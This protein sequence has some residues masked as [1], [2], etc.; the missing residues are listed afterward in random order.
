MSWMNQREYPKISIVTPNY[1]KA[2]YLERTILSVLSQNYPNLEYII[3]DGGSTD[4]SVDIIK[5]YADKLTY[6]V[7]E[8]DNGMYYAIKKGFEY[9][10]GEIMAW[11][12]SDDMYHPGA[13]SIVADI[14]ME[15]D[16]V[17]WLTGMNTH[18]DE[19]G[20]TVRVWSATYFSH[21]SFLM[22]NYKYVQQ[23][24]T[25]WRRSL[26]NRVGGISTEYKLAGDFNLWMR[27]SRHE[28]MYIVNALLG[29][30]RV[31]DG[32]LSENI[33]EYS[34]EAEDIIAK[35]RALVEEGKQIKKL[36]IRYRVISFIQKFKVLNWQAIDKKFMQEFV[37][38]ENEHR[39]NFDAISKRFIKVVK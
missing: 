10:T 7:S 21:L 31:C 30:F 26:W 16:D 34:R 3:I 14:F 2:K 29:G 35:E 19:N 18:Y 13:L 9:S 8:P 27:F 6:W 1:N 17:Q 32:Q 36:K 12:N 22:R 4:G 39:I 28:K 20:R 24:S 15:Y 5:K 23:E 38:E 37:E 11:I 25:F 33:K